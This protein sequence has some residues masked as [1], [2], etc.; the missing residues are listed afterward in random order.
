VREII[1]LA[2]GS[3]VVKVLDGLTGRDIDEDGVELHYA[4][5]RPA[6]RAASA[7]QSG[8]CASS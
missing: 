5:G 4:A 6:R 1:N 3:W 7:A 8:A 2:T